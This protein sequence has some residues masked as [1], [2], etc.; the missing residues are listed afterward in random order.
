[1][2]GKQP[3]IRQTFD[4][5]TRCFLLCRHA[6][7]HSH[8]DFATNMQ[9]LGHFQVSKSCH[10]LSVKARACQVDSVRSA[11]LYQ[12]P[13]IIA[14]RACWLWSRKVGCEIPTCPSG[15]PRSTRSL[16]EPLQL[17]GGPE[18]FPLGVRKG[19]LLLR[20]IERASQ[21]EQSER[22]E[23]SSTLLIHGYTAFGC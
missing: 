9:R 2:H 20:H 3:P 13:P 1:M 21:E 10:I 16:L 17:L 22:T 19:L 14:V 6:R 15:L 18:G 11:F 4:S 23:I 7:R 5:C 12:R 8:A